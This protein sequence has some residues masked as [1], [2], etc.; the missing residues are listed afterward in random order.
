ME[1][2]QQMNQLYET[3]RTKRAELAEILSN[4][5]VGDTDTYDL[6]SLDLEEIARREN[7]LV[8]LQQQY[9]L[10]MTEKR[11][12]RM[13]EREYQIPARDAIP[14]PAQDRSDWAHEF[15]NSAQF[16]SYR[17][18]PGQ[19]SDVYVAPDLEL[20]AVMST[21]AGFAPQPIRTGRVADMA[22]SL[23]LNVMDVVTIIPTD[24][25]AV[26]YM[27]ETTFSDNAAAERTEGAAY[28]EAS[29]VY[30]QRTSDVRSI[31]VFIPVTD[32]QLTDIAGIEQRI[33]QRLGL[34]V[35]RRLANQILN[36]NGTAPN[37]RGILNTSGIQ[38]FARGSTPE[39]SALFDAIN[40]VSNLYEDQDANAI[41]IHP[42][43]WFQLVTK[44]TTDG[45]YIFGPPQQSV[46][47]N[48][49][50]IPVVVT[51]AVPENTVLVGDFGYH[52]VAE[53]VGL[54]FQ[55]GY[56]ND[57]FKLGQRSIRCNM[58]VANVVE[59]PVAFCAVTG[60]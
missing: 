27:E 33:Q 53:R 60:F 44:M 55:I 57:D 56:V 31:A 51:T 54:D 37:L 5:R 4:A 28:A 19:V 23:R 24:Q 21:S 15:V 52:Y 46:P 39:F 2:K 17:P 50:G 8:E 43:D 9:E 58:R 13:Q 6:Q 40:R 45:L 38:T 59:R 29:L 32:E 7:E 30:T 3:L 20:R 48:V 36:G 22:I 14:L 11:L 35:Q 10:K 49:Y 25:S 16:R 1:V 41:I 12:K 47:I 42:N 34:M 18:A 26:V